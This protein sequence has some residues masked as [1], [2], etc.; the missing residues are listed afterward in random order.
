MSALAWWLI[1]I[2]ATVLAVTFVILRGRPQKPTTAED[3]M[4]SLRR[5]QQAMER[6][7]PRDSASPPPGAADDDEV[8]NEGRR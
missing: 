3:S 1:P 5:M 8:G 7:M 6:P 2:G 4:A